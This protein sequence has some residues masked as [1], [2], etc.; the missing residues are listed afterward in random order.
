MKITITSR[1]AWEFDQEEERLRGNPRRCEYFCG[2]ITLICSD[3]E[4]TVVTPDSDTL[5]PEQMNE[6]LETIDIADVHI[7]E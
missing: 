6:L 7:T 4:L 5:T 3:I 1:E 2:N